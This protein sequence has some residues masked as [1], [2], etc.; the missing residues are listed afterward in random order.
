MLLVNESHFDDDCRKINEIYSEIFSQN[1]R[2]PKFSEI[3]EKVENYNIGIAL[4]SLQWFFSEYSSDSEYSAFISSQ[5]DNV[6]ENKLGSNF[7]MDFYETFES[8]NIVFEN[9]CVMHPMY[10][11]IQSLDGYR[12]I[13]NSGMLATFLI[14]EEYGNMDILSFGDYGF[15]DLTNSYIERIKDE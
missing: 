1:N 5:I 10:I 9:D 2:I 15:D 8:L 13:T 6:L 4:D 7:Y 14:S 12:V 3:Y 11:R